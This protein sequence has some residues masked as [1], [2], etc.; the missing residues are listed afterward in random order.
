MNRF[1]IA[2]PSRPCP[3]AVR[4]GV[5]LLEAL[6]CILAVTAGLWLGAYLLGFNVQMLA[7]SA[8]ADSPIIEQIPKDW[9][10]APPKGMELPTPEELAAELRNELHELRLEVARLQ[11][12]P[13]LP[14]AENLTPP[15]TDSSDGS[16][17]ARRQETL[18][19]WLRLGEIRTEVERL[20]S[21]AEE[22]LNQQNVWKVLE[23]RRRAYAY[24]AKAVKAAKHDVVDPQALQF[25]KQLSAWY[26][27]GGELYS[28]AMNVWQ[29]QHLP[30]EG[31]PS[32]Q[33]LNQARQQHDNEAMLLFE[34]GGRLREVLIRRYQIAFPDLAEDSVEIPAESQQN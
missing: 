25:A 21:S 27:Q 33:W 29:S 7:Y 9:R 22:A 31:L 19:F 28:E 18:A 11:Q 26:Q 15:A 14:E 8:L 34:K 6:G 20:Q 32:D 12:E 30:P 10:P 3:P 4:Q 1:A 13:Q 23:V 2:S 16:I 5:S 17:A 24:G